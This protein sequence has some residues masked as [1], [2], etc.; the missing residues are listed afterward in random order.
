MLIYNQA[1]QQCNEVNKLKFMNEEKEKI[2]MLKR[3]N[4]SW[5]ARQLGKEIEKDNVVFDNAVQ[6]GLVWDDERKSLLVHSMATGYPIPPMYA[7]KED[8]KF[9][10]LDG[11]QRS[12]CIYD[13]LND[14]FALKNVP[15]VTLDDGEEIDINGKLFS[16]LDEDLRDTISN[17][18]LTVYYFD[19]ITE[20]EIAELFFRIN[21]GRALSS[22]E[23]SRTRAVSLK[24]IQEIGQHELFHTSLTEKAFEKYTHEDLVIKSYIM[25]FSDEKCLDTKVVRPIMETA[26]FTADEIEIM[27]KVY[28]RILDAYK[29]I[30]ADDSKENAKNNKK[31]AKRL[32]TR[33]HML[34]ILPI[35]KRS[36]DEEV[37]IEKFAAWAKSFF[38]G[39]KHATKHSEYN[40]RCASGSGHLDSVKVRLK[41]VKKDYEDFMKNYKEEEVVE[42]TEIADGD[43]TAIVTEPTETTESTDVVADIDATNVTDE[44]VV[45]ETEET[46]VETETETVTVEETTEEEK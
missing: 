37:S 36:I 24:T 40:V 22:V 32:I 33:T 28:D 20:D 12:N 42:V 29:L 5:N 27:N 25:L 9:S 19:G 18:P 39:S 10:M 46:K 26:V 35:V 44:T 21:N 6:R 16:E 23:L 1:K 17:Y 15:P 41:V 45:T 4:I 2:I 31:Y 30:I 11:K 34:S 8:E 7:A 13:F 3:A 14:K 38:S 43:E